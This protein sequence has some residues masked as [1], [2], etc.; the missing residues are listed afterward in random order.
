[1]FEDCCDCRAEYIWVTSPICKMACT[2]KACTPEAGIKLPK[3]YCLK[4]QCLLAESAV[5]CTADKDCKKVDDCCYCMA[6]PTSTTPETC[7]NMCFINTCTGIGLANAT[8]QCVGGTCRL[9]P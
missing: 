9:V 2:V 3:A 8:P 7:P 1:M 4:G 6:V 5:G